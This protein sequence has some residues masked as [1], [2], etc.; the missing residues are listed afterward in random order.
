MFM[1][2]EGKHRKTRK[3]TNMTH[4]EIVKMPKGYYVKKIYGA[5]IQMQFVKTK[6]EAD[7]LIKNWKV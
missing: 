5:N 6:K 2:D 1:K 7:E 4:F 3:E